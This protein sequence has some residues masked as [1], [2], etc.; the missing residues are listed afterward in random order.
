MFRPNKERTT[1]SSALSC[2][3]FS[4][5]GYNVISVEASHQL[6]KRVRT[7]SSLM[8]LQLSTVLADHVQKGN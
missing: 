6:I 7:L 3:L 2:L 8:E 5:M 1:K 4:A